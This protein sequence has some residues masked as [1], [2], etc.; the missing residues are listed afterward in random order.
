MAEGTAP[1]SV[2]TSSE[3]EAD[4]AMAT[5]VHRTQLSTPGGHSL[6]MSMDALARVLSWPACVCVSLPVC[7]SFACACFSL[8]HG[9]D[10]RVSASCSQA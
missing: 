5:A 6:G 4:V 3:E 7:V 8:A 10:E 1:A 2:M 9:E